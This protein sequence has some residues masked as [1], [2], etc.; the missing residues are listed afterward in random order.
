M[1]GNGT[2][3]QRPRAVRWARRSPRSGRI[4][5]CAVHRAELSEPRGPKP[6]R[7]VVQGRIPRAGRE[8]VCRM[9]QGKARKTR[10]RPI[11]RGAKFDPRSDQLWPARSGR[12]RRTRTGDEPARP[13]GQAQRLVVR[14]RDRVQ[15]RS[16]GPGIRRPASQ[17]RGRP[18]Q[19]QR[20]LDA[21]PRLVEALA[22][23]GPQPFR[24]RPEAGRRLQAQFPQQCHGCQLDERGAIAPALP[25]RGRA[26]AAHVLCA[27]FSHRPRQV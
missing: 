24:Q 4:R 21:I 22:Q 5:S 26:G 10:W 11:A 14:G 19:R 12:T 23:G 17:R 3:K 27:R 6:R 25:R 15:I 9:G 16:C 1:A 20:D 7:Q 18:L 13:G 2:R 8:M